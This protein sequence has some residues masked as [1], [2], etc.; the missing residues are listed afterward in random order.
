MDAGNDIVAKSSGVDPVVVLGVIFVFIIAGGLIWGLYMM[1]KQKK[2]EVA[3]AAAKETTSVKSK[4]VSERGNGP[5][6]DT[7]WLVRKVERIEDGI[8]VTDNG[9]RF[10]AAITCRGVDLYNAGRNEQLSVMRG[11]Q[12]FYNIVEKPI[13][14][15]QYCKAIDLDIPKGRYSAKYEEV[16]AEYERYAEALQSAREHQKPE[17]EIQ[18][19]AFAANRCERRL[20]HLEAQM[21][22]IE[23]HSGSDVVMDV[24]QDYIFDWTYEPGVSDVKLTDTEIFLRAKSELN[25]IA[26]HK[27][28]ALMATGVKGRMCTQ[29]EMVGMFRH[30][31]KPIGAEVYKQKMLRESSFEEDIVT[32]DSIAEATQALYEEDVKRLQESIFGSKEGK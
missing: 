12:K 26:S 15:R 22:M 20:N 18:R 32:S 2:G 13:T 19:L 30:H 11:Y 7:R 28:D 10:V 16:M 27:I 4:D 14:Y 17:E 23:F 8:V 25:A 24:T 9:K 5:I 3:T 29:D 21:R 6:Q 31:S 1:Y